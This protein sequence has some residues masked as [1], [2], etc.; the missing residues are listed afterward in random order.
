MILES[1]AVPP[2]E[3]NGFVMGWDTP[4]RRRHRPWRRRRT[5][6]RGDQTPWALDSLHPAHSCPPRP[7]HR[8][9]QGQGSA[10]RAGRAA[11]RRQFPVGA[12]VQQGQAFG[13]DVDPQPPVD[14]FYDGMGP[15]S[16]GNYSAWVHRTPGH[17]PGGSASL[18]VAMATP[19][20]ALSVTRCLPDRSA[21]RTC[22]AA[23]CRQQRSIREV[24]FSFPDETVVHSGHGNRRRSERTDEPVLNS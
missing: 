18:S 22:L 16:F 24:L 20:G 21:A 12:V 3:E 19:D 11:P 15:W 5:A 9:R 8:R 17:C 14:Q 13:F 10:R 6:P 23:A 1:R 4:G 7:H 2:F